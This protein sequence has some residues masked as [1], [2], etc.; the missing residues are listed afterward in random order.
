MSRGPRWHKRGRVHEADLAGDV[1]LRAARMAPWPDWW[2]EVRTPDGVRAGAW[3][4]YE[5][6]GRGTFRAAR[7]EAEEAA[8]KMGLMAVGG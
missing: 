8:T 4:A 3:V 2:W 5:E 1:R 6:H 7:R